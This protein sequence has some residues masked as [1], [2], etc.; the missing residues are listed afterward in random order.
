M[1]QKRAL[2]LLGD[3]CRWLCSYSVALAEF[4]DTQLAGALSPATIIDLFLEEAKQASQAPIRTSPIY[5]CCTAPAGSV[6]S[7]C[8]LNFDPARPRRYAQ[9]LTT[10][11]AIADGGQKLRIEAGLGLCSSTE[12]MLPILRQQG[13]VLRTA[14]ALQPLLFTECL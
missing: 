13:Y 2:T 9:E 8:I 11:D 3:R 10:A 1:S 4:H 14:F 6:P 12:R 7:L 5:T